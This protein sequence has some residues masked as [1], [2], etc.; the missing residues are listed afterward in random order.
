[1]SFGDPEEK[2][3]QWPANFGSPPLISL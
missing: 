3:G 1:V 2:R